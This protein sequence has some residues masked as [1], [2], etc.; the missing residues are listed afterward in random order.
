[1][2]IGVSETE[3]IA[4]TE[5]EAAGTEG[6]DASVTTEGTETEGT[7]GTEGTEA[8]AADV[9][10]SILS[11]NFLLTSI[12]NVCN[13]NI[14]VF[15]PSISIAMISVRLLNSSIHS[16]VGTSGSDDSGDF[17][18]ATN[19]SK[20]DKRA[21]TKLITCGR[22]NPAAD[23]CGCCRSCCCLCCIEGGGGVGS[24]KLALRFLAAASDV[25]II[26]LYDLNTEVIA[27]ES[28]AYPNKHN[29]SS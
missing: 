14:E 10:L 5:T 22:V 1:M 19:F 24:D 26:N 20:L 11:N 21:S 15:R 25:L 29:T 27:E 12:V 18:S 2:A 13:C 23:P 3:G 8:A 17:C 4:G 7:E 28:N 16:D 9:I 6:T